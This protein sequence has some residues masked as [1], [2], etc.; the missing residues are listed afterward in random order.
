MQAEINIDPA[1]REPLKHALLGLLRKMRIEEQHPAQPETRHDR[2]NR[3]PGAQLAVRQGKQ[4]DGPRRR[5]REKQNNPRKY[6]G[7]G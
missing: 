7:H 5:Q 2:A 3:K 1:N 6:F 4:R